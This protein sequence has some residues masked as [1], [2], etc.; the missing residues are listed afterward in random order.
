MLGPI[1][2][3]WHNLQY[4]QDLM[5]DLREAIETKK[6]TPTFAETFKKQGKAHGDSRRNLEMFS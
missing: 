5:R 1:L 3:S 4:Y 2:L 6:L